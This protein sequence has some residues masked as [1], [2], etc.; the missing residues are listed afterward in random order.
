[1][2]RLTARSAATVSQVVW[3]ASGEVGPAESAMRLKAVAPQLRLFT[4]AAIFSTMF[5]ARR[6]LGSES[7]LASLFWIALIGAGI[8]AAGYMVPV[9][10]TIAG[11]GAGTVIGTSHYGYRGSSGTVAAAAAA[12]A[13]LVPPIAFPAAVACAFAVAGA[14]NL[15]Q[16]WSRRADTEWLFFVL[17]TPLLLILTAGSPYLVAGSDSWSHNGPLILFFGGL[18]IVNAPFD[19]AS[20]GL[21]RLLL[22]RGV[23]QGGPWP[24]LYAIIDAALASLLIIA[25]AITM[26]IAVDIFDTLAVLRGGED[27][28][29][30]PPMRMFL[31][32]IRENPTA[33]RYWW[34]HATLFST[35]IPSIVKKFGM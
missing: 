16:Q 33:W 24:Y 7:G 21:T 28:R 22:W 35:M 2:A 3:C 12:A 11:V 6:A 9:G 1:M 29:V 31:A 5:V 8:I 4:V 17:Y 27:A 13:F 20:L 18:T 15:V 30:L 10:T 23:E 14:F 34:V 25:L 26:V 32:E 19:W